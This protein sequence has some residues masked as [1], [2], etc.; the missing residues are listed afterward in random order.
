[1]M[2]KFSILSLIVALTMVILIAGFGCKKTEQQAEAPKSAQQ[3]ATPVAV[4]EFKVTGGTLD[5]GG[6][7]AVLASLK[8]K[9]ATAL[10]KTGTPFNNSITMKCRIKS[11]L[12]SGVRN[13]AVVFG[14]DPYKLTVVRVYIGEMTFGIEGPLVEKVIKPAKFDQSKE[15]DLELVAD[16]KKG[17]IITKIDGN[18]VS[19]T[20]KI[21]PKSINYVGYSA[22]NTKTEF[23]DIQIS[24]D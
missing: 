11:S 13:G 15:F 8:D 19:T 23:S 21:K 7:G 12:P 24:G 10:K 3:P 20:M 1:M 16:I 14:E 17:T 6:I 9:G 22:W 2:K 4:E 5:K 18:E